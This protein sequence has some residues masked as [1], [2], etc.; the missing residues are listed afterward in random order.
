[1]KYCADKRTLKT[2]SR[3]SDP[4]KQTKMKQTQLFSLKITKHCQQNC[5]TISIDALQKIKITT[6][7]KQSSF[8]ASIVAMKLNKSMGKNIS[9]QNLAY[10][11]LVCLVDHSRSSAVVLFHIG[12]DSN[13]RIF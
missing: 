5:M 6:V 2:I 11:N 1:V 10:S 3:S 13:L 4:D 12:D 9:S 7:L 8:I